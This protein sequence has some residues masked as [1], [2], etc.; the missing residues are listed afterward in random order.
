MD[1]SHR[2]ISNA[3]SIT[4]YSLYC[5]SQ[6]SSMPFRSCPAT[7]CDANKTHSFMIDDVDEIAEITP[8][9][10]GAAIASVEREND[11]Y[12]IGQAPSNI[13]EDNMNYRKRKS[14]L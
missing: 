6:Q 10:L 11:L 5:H 4:S 8:D 3:S 7:P 2:N 1:L 9:I 13:N 14:M 12:K